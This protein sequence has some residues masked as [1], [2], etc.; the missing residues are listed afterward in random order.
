MPLTKI[1]GGRHPA[2]Y[3]EGDKSQQSGAHE[4]ADPREEKEEPHDGTLHGLWGCR[5]GKFKACNNNNK[6]IGYKIAVGFLKYNSL[7]ISSM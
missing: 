1:Y 6:Q 4:R 3:R 5:I 7:L 2:N